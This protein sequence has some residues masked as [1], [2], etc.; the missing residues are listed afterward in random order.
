MA[1]KL[2]GITVGVHVLFEK[3]V[4]GEVFTAVG[5]RFFH[6]KG[7]A[8]ALSVVISKVDG[9]FLVLADGFATGRALVGV[10]RL[11]CSQKT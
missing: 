10:L 1:D 4:D 8:I 3:I 11:S 5:T 6:R 9:I 7:L 2:F